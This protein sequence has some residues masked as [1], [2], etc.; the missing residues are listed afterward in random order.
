MLLYTNLVVTTNQNRYTHTK[1]EREPNI[2]LKIVIKSQGKR[3]KQEERNQKVTK[4]T[5][6]HK[7]VVSTYISIITLNINRLNA[8]IKRRRVA[9]W[10]KRKR[11]IY[12]LPTRGSLQI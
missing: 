5:R 10:I 1:R 11:P 9:E 6:K 8:P 12:V 2:T 4:T 3:T 7:M